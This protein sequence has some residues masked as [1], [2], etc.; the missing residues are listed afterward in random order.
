MRKIVIGLA[1]VVIALAIYLFMVSARDA[2]DFAGGK[3]VGLSDYK[4]ANPTGVPAELAG[5]DLVTRGEYLTRA[6]DCLACH[7][8]KGGQPFAGGLAFRLPFGT[9]YSPNITPDKETGIGNW[10]D[11][12]FLRAVHEGIARDGTRLYPA[13]PYASYS[14]LADADVLAIKAYLFSLAPI[15]APLQ[16]ST[17][18]FPYNQRWLMAI[19]SAVFRP[20]ERFRPNVEQSAQWNRGAY[21]SEALAHCG[22]CHTP[23]SALQGLNERKKFSG[24]VIAGWNAYNITSDPASGIGAWQADE[25]AQYLSTGHADGRGTASGPM[26]EAVDLS[27]RTLSRAD[28]EA[29]V[30]YVRSVPAIAND[31][32]PPKRTEPAPTS[33]LAGVPE[34]VDPRGKHVFAGACASCHDWSGV[35]PLTPHA[36]LVGTRAVNDPSG[37]NVVQI[38]ISGEHGGAQDLTHMPSFGHAYSDTEIAAV[39]NYVIARFGGR[40]SNITAREV[41]ELRGQTEVGSSN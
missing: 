7:T 29:L 23:R 5:A 19:W 15:H 30:A 41:A 14:Y 2:M 20:G 34:N 27:L 24:A 8:V 22:E 39:T 1:V 32:S 18:K 12:E 31:A 11:A 26:R 35:S 17:L 28:I 16:E 6:A 4:E 36:T 38:V 10:S 13:F 9:L 37:I 40:T 21:L 3:T 33:H 25:L